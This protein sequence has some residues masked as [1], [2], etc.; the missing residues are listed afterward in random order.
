MRLTAIHFKIVTFIFVFL[1]GLFTL[2]PMNVVQAWN[3]G[4]KTFKDCLGWKVKAYPKP[5]NQGKEARWIPVEITGTGEGT[6]Q[7]GQTHQDYTVSIKW[8]KETRKCTYHWKC[9]DWEKSDVF[10]EESDSGKVFKPKHCG[11]PT[12][13]PTETPCPSPTPDVTPEPTPEVTPEPTPEPEEP[14]EPEEEW[15]NP[16]SSSLANDNLNCDN[17]MFD[18]VVDLKTNDQP[19]KDIV[20]KFDFNG[21]L[22]EARTNEFGR[23][24][25]QFPIEEGAVYIEAEDFPDQSQVITPPDCGEDNGIGGGDVLGAT[26]LAETGDQ[27]LYQTLALMMVGLS[28]S[29]LSAYA[30]TQAQKIQ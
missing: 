18:A 26:T 10:H 3:E 5:F 4:V 9:S 30:Y 7:D 20:V 2:A 28:V 6:W 13:T 11:K 15:V 22:K 24:R 25:V 29:L 1:V 8:Q 21:E 14:E 17:D 12:P 27:T 16:N 23:A 19:A